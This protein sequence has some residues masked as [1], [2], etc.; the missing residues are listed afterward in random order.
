MRAPEILRL[1][2]QHDHFHADDI[3]SDKLGIYGRAP[4]ETGRGLRE[5]GG[6]SFA[7]D[8]PRGPRFRVQPGCVIAASKTGAPLVPIGFECRSKKR[9]RSWDRFV[10]PWPF[11]RVQ[12][13]FGEEIRVPP[14]LSRDEIA[15]WCVR[16][17]EAMVDVTREAAEAVGVPAETPDDVDQA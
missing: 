3:S 12:V 9:L 17:Q 2:A 14:D 4:V 7:I 13:I 8:G 11:T 6:A 5:G 1:R 10:L 15:D 16:V